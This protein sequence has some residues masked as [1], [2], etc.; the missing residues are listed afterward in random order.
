MELIDKNDVIAEIS[1]LERI[2]ENRGLDAGIMSDALRD[3]IEEMKI[4]VDG[5]IQ[6]LKRKADELDRVKELARRMKA[7]ESVN[8]P[9]GSSV[10][11]VLFPGLRSGDQS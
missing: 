4:T 6:E 3:S 9:A 11:D 1:R 8:A 2:A 10:Y 7:G 5:D